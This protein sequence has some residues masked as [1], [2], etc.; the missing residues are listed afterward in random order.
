MKVFMMTDLEGPCGVNGRPDAGVGN[1]IINTEIAC[2]ALTN[3]VN[4]CV[5]GLVKAGVDTVV[6]V[7]GH[8]GSS[9]LN[10][11]DMHPAVEL[12]QYGGEF[13]G[14]MY[15]SGYDA[16]VFIGAHSMQQ[17][18]GF[19][20]HSF[21]SHGVSAI[22]LNG[23]PIGE[24]GIQTLIAAYFKT[25]MILVSGDD[26]ACR[27]ATELIGNNLV[28]VPTKRTITRYAV[29]NF[30]PTRVYEAI[31]S[32]SE[33][34]FLA[35]KEIPVVKIPKKLE[36][37]YRFMCRNTADWAEAQGGERIDEQTVK[38]TDTDF[39]RLWLGKNLSPAAFQNHFAN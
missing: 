4:A 35:R 14:I 18:G 12:I 33:K 6:V 21:N 8:G 11:F 36:L 28:T 17:A 24:I 15:E 29:H 32:A 7:D 39:R 26:Y 16:N 19:M 5:R 38:Y 22:W 23:K 3:E 31:E 2:R 10:V 37:T 9:S 27:E 34:A 20:C 1:K 25:P 30:S 13:S